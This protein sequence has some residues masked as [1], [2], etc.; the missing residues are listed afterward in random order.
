M[1]EEINGFVIDQYN[2][3]KLE[4]KTQGICPMCS[5]DRKPKNVKAKKLNSENLR[6]ENLEPAPTSQRSYNITGV[7]LTAW[8]H[9][10]KLNDQDTHDKQRLVPQG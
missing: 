7:L 10:W 1:V 9:L 4:E 8:L 2:V 5:H 6:F 3:H